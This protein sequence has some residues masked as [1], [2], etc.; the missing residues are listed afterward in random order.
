MQV[1]FISQSDE[2][3]RKR[4]IEF[5]RLRPDHGELKDLLDKLSEKG[6]GAVGFGKG[7]VRF[8]THLD[9]SDDMLDQTIEILKGLKI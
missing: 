4:V 2:F 7:L 3:F 9:F 5:R 6:I 8:V 1:C